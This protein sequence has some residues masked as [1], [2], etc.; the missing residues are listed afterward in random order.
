MARLRPEPRELP[1][2]DADARHRSNVQR[3]LF[4][5]ALVVAGNAPDL[6]F[7][8][9]ILVG[10]PG[11]FHHGPAH[12]L[13]AAVCFAAVMAPFARACGVRSVRRFGVL[14]GLV[15]ASHLF[16]DMLSSDHGI[17]NG[18]PL[19]WPLS[20][21]A[22]SLP[23]AIFVDIK[24]NVD[25]RSFVRSLLLWSN[26]YSVLRELGVLIGAFALMQLWRRAT[27]ASK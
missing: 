13:G 14:M 8:P 17:R 9:G 22:F 5:A 3:G 4:L 6:D 1:S 26:V 15:F 25:T 12:S 2:S 23:V 10:D 18:V 11:L 21:Q 19:F 16:L 7:I 20:T 24:R 27:A